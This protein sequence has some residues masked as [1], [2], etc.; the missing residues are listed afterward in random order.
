VRHAGLEVEVRTEGKAVELAPGLDISAYRIV[1]EALT[2]ALK[3]AGEARA[4][5]LVSFGPDNL[6]IEVSDDGP[7]G[8]P[9]G[10]GHGLA[11]L[12]ERVALF[13][14]TLEAGPRD[15]GG[16]RVRAR[17]PIERVAP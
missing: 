5:V 8:T 14:G 17:L 1:Q 7:G 10:G 2:N 4:S 16:F 6:E 3:H 15:H 13:G 11:G 12:R 9:N